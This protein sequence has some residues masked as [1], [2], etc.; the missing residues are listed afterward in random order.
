M[1]GLLVHR[2]LAHQDDDRVLVRHRTA[3][4]RD[5]PEVFLEPLD[6]VRRVYHR[7]D[8]RSVVQVREVERNVFIVSR[9]FPWSRIGLLLL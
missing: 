7:L 1:V 6:P 5:T 8:L 4:P 9:Y 2:C 3:H